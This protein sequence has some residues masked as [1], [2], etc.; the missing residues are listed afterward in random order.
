M[1]GRYASSRSA[2]DLAAEFEVD[3]IDVQEQLSPDYNVAPT[4]KSPVVL[5]R[6]PK[7]APDDAEPV[8]RTDDRAE[9]RCVPVVSG[10]GDELADPRDERRAGPGTDGTRGH[11]RTAEMASRSIRPTSPERCTPSRTT[12]SPPTT[13]SVTSAAVA[14]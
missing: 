9:N 7:D 13:V 10:A 2:D 4:K 11:R 3:Q 1:C 8:L 5:A 6:L 12:C 14:A